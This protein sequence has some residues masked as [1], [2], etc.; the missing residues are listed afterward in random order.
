VSGTEDDDSDNVPGD[1]KSFTG[2]PEDKNTYNWVRVGSLTRLIT[3]LNG[4]IGNTVILRF[5]VVTNNDD[6][7][8]FHDALEFKG[9]YVDDIRVYGES[10]EGTRS[11]GEEVLRQYHELVARHEAERGPSE[12][13]ASI[14]LPTRM[15]ISPA[16]IYEDDGESASVE[17]LGTPAIIIAG[18]VL[19][20]VPFAVARTGRKFK[21]TNRL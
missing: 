17:E 14:D 21:R 20:A 13:G 18:G 15:A 1:G 6:P 7:D 3:N 9:L 5:R 16:E 8:H 12:K 10:L 4:F 11:S 2:L 19:I